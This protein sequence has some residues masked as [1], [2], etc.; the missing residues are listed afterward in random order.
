MAGNKPLTK[1]D[2]EGVFRSVLKE[3]PT[4]K[5]MFQMVSQ[6]NDA[7]IS[8]VEKMMDGL[9]D[10]MHRGFD[11]LKSGQRDLQRQINDLKADT[12]TMKE[13]TE[14]KEKVYYHH[15]AN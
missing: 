8:G 9:R 14:L 3:Y 4:K 1:K 15:P 10:E 6:S 12:P 11:E 13:F 7:V 2:I 5:D